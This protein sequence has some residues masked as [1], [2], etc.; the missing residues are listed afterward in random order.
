M[1]HLDIAPW[2]PEE[3]VGKLWHLMASRMDPPPRFPEAAVRFDAMRGRIAVLFR[4]LGGGAD[5]EMKPVADQVGRHRISL[6]RRLAFEAEHLPRASFDGETLR[7]PAELAAFPA[8]GDNEALYLWLA[9]A[10]AHAPDARA[11]T[12]PFRADLAAIAAGMT[13]TRA[14][15]QAAP[16]LRPLWQRLCSSH[17]SLRQRPALRGTEAAVEALIRHLLGDPALPEEA[18][19]RNSPRRPR[20]GARRRAIARRLRCRCGPICADFLPAPQMRSP[21]CR[22]RAHPR[23]PATARPARPAA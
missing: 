18:L 17:L 22:H 19:W 16:G 15:L 14:T 21:A 8:A 10:A 1:A 4:G 12:D 5:V 20:G 9:A 13:M 3:T 7:L 11:E 6:R 2:E 23:N